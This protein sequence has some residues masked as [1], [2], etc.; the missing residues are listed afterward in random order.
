MAF[1]YHAKRQ[2]QAY[3]SAART[4]SPADF[5]A[6]VPNGAKGVQ[7]V[8]NT[9][10]SATP[11]TVVNVRA[12]ATSVA[13]DP[14]ILASAAIAANGQI[15]LNI[16]PEIASVANLSAS[17]YLPKVIVIDPVHGNANSHTYNIELIWQY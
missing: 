15:L 13:T 16:G 11:S 5:V 9:T 7:V 6:A 12:R 17:S 14:L 3:A 1:L 10:A 4:A 8:I 2:E